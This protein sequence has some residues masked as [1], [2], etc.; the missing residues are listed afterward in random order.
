MSKVNGTTDNT[1]QCTICS[2]DFD[3]ELEG[4]GCV[5]ELGILPINLCPTCFTG[6]MDLLDQVRPK[7]CPEC[8]GELQSVPDDDCD[9]HDLPERMQ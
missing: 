3:T 5:G 6:M 9:P 4:G 2:G 7:E 8:G 1:L